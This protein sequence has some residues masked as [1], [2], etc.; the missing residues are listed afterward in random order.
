[1]IFFSISAIKWKNCFV[2]SL[3]G[4]SFF[5]ICFSVPPSLPWASLVAQLAKNL[6][7]MQK[8]QVCP[9]VGKIPW[10]RKWL[11]TSVF[12]SGEFHGER[13][14]TG[15]IVCGV[16]KSQTWLSNFFFFHPVIPL[17]YIKGP[18]Q[19]QHWNLLPNHHNVLS[20]KQF[21]PLTLSSL[22]SRTQTAYG[23]GRVL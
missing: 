19:H 6:P 23:W 8:T 12:L 1:M 17:F 10:R 15:Y 18:N 16:A 7:A 22:Y 9:W 5:C 14:R 3:W 20:W 13:S 4:S 11:P 21:H 2:F